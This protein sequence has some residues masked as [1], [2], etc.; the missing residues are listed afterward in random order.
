MLS[1][2][3][4]GSFRGRPLQELPR[5]PNVPLLRSNVPDG[6]TEDVAPVELRVR[7]EHLTRRVDAL[8]QVLVLLVRAGASAP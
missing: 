2:Y 8:L 6:E 5:A 3:G 4:H 1:R 7:D